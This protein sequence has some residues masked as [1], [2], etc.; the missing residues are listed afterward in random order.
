LDVDIGPY[1]LPCS[2][3]PRDNMALRHLNPPVPEEVSCCSQGLFMTSLHVTS[4]AAQLHLTPNV[5]W[6][7]QKTIHTSGLEE[8]GG[9]A[10][11]CCA[12]PAWDFC[13]ALCSGGCSANTLAVSRRSRKRG[14]LDASQPYGPLRP[15]HRHLWPEYLRNMGASTSHTPKGLHGHLTAICGPVSTEHGNLDVSHP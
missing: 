8:T 13:G 6:G 1:C 9:Y 10:C 11:S 14:N 2:V 12:I 3:A 5:T 7:K 15:P 4:T